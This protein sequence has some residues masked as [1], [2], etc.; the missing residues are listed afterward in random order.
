MSELLFSTFKRLHRALRGTGLG[1]VKLLRDLRDAIYR[2]SRPTSPMVVEV[3]GFKLWVDPST[4]GGV[5]PWLLLDNVHEPSETRCV[6]EN[7]PPGGTFI[8]IGANIGYYTVLAARLVGPGGRV[9]GFEP[10]PVNFDTLQKN[11]ALNEL[12]NVTAE[13]LACSD[14]AADI[15]LF[16]DESNAGGHHLHDTSDGAKAT[17]IRAVALDEYFRG[18]GRAI[19]LI[20][21]DI[22]GHEPVAL[23]GMRDLLGRH[24]GAKLI[25]E[26][27]AP[28]IRKA[29]ESPEGYL[30][31]LRSLGFRF[32]ILSDYGKAIENAGAPEIIARCH[33]G[34]FVNLFCSR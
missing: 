24:P 8:D 13:P 20:K 10:E 15:P 19:D 4:A 27:D 25:T 6:R 3:G 31:G 14:R 22:Q 18:S 34:E 2:V 21:M 17:I 9:Y 30:E 28:M 33:N 16:L 32:T 12:G 26:F 29:G 7:L 11:I 23:R 1:R 5:V